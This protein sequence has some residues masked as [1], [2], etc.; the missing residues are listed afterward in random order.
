MNVYLAIV[1]A[2][3]VTIL[4][5]WAY[6]TAQRLN[7]LHI[8][9][10]SALAQ[11]ISALDRRDALMAALEPELRELAQTSLS[12]AG[13]PEFVEAKAKADSDVK[14]QLQNRTVAADIVDASARVELA[15]RFYNDAVTSTRALRTRRLVRFLRLGGTAK[16]PRYFDVND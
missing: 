10:D 4:A 12:I 14:C 15:A 16:L 6:F 7:R 2:V 3:V 1:I 11:L 9:T 8:R 5:A 13:S